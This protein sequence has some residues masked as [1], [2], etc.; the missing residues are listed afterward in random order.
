M[1]ATASVDVV[2]RQVRALRLLR[3]CLSG[4][5]I[6]VFLSHIW[7]APSSYPAAAPSRYLAVH[8]YS[9]LPTQCVSDCVRVRLRHLSRFRQLLRLPQSLFVWPLP[10]LQSAPLR[11][12]FRPLFR[13]R[14][15][16]SSVTIRPLLTLSGHLH[17]CVLCCLS[18]FSPYRSAL[19]KSVPLCLD[20]CP[21]VGGSAPAI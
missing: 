19:R 9:A 11:P 8:V 16:H 17:L 14:S 15:C 1:A 13:P 5:L 7:P 12:L 6:S 10:L 18:S 4:S 3:L 2:L 20:R 21:V